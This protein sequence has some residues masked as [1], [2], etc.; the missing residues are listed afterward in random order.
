MRADTRESKVFDKGGGVGED[1]VW[2]EME[3]WRPYWRR[4]E[5]GGRTAMP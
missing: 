4:G 3:G 2:K 1:S 5:N